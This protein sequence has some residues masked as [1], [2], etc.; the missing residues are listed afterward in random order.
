MSHIDCWCKILTNY[1]LKWQLDHINWNQ[2]RQNFDTIKFCLQ[3]K[4]LHTKYVVNIKSTKNKQLA[5]F[6]SGGSQQKCTSTDSTCRKSGD[7]TCRTYEGPLDLPYVWGATRLAVWGAPR[8]TVW[9]APRLAVWGAPRLDVWVVTRLAVWGTPR[10]AVWGATWLALWVRLDLPYEGRLDLP[11][12]CA[13]TCH[14]KS[15]KLTVEGDLEIVSQNIFVWNSSRSRDAAS[16][17]H[18]QN[19]RTVFRRAF[20]IKLLVAINIKDV[21]SAGLI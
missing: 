13:S 9:G 8:L 19:I 6:N 15:Q 7:S 1:L 11:C 3:C 14:V 16:A 5:S 10:L 2:R 17:Y 12:G 18:D 20:I 21:S 4:E